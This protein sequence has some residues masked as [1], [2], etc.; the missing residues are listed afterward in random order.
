MSNVRRHVRDSASTI[1][2]RLQF[3][4]ISAGF[5]AVLGV[6]AS[7][8]VLG[9]FAF[10]GFPHPFNCWMVGF[11]AGFFFFVGVLRGAESADTVADAFNVVL[12]VA[13]AG[14]GIAG[15]GVTTVDGNPEW[16][17]SLWW[18]VFY[19]SGMVLLAWLA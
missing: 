11:S 3:G 15:G 18:G 16:R 17:P 6:F 8:V 5:G 9:I 7:L 2:D 1:A 19:F 10:S 14:V 4:L 13:L 12:V